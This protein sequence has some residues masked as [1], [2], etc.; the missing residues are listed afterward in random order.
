MSGIEWT[1]ETWNPVVGCTRASRGCD[2]CYAVAMTHRLEAMGQERYAGLTVL[3]GR[4]DRHFNGVVRCVPEALDRPLRW[5]KPRRVFVNSMADL[6]HPEV[7]FEFIDRVFA[8][9]ALTPQHTY[10]VLTKRPER[11]AEYLSGEHRTDDAARDVNNPTTQTL[12]GCTTLGIACELEAKGWKY[13]GSCILNDDAGVSGWPLPN[14]WLGTSVEDQAAANERVPHLLRC[15]AA[16]RFLSCEPL[17]GPVNL[18]RVRIDE[19]RTMNAFRGRWAYDNRY[20]HT[21][22]GIADPNNPGGPGDSKI[23]WV[24]VGGESGPK[25]RRCDVA[26]IRLILGQC[27]QSGVPVFVKQLGDRPQWHHRH[28]DAPPF[29]DGVRC[30]AKDA[31]N[32]DGV[33]LE[34]RTKDRK[35]GDPEE[36]PEDLRVRQWPGEDGNAPRCGARAEPV[37]PPARRKD[38][39]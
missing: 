12:V 15:P 32:G 6:F 19:Q 4:G 2:N 36:W 5:R 16:V 27:E 7:P 13:G 17:L 39:L 29:P 21:D 35:G 9:M 38:E 3:N 28:G 10:Q 14:V 20:P 11:M 30:D 31:E 18:R 33:V 8:V 34:F 37:A 22:G 26:W 24:I 23:D 1:D 25:A